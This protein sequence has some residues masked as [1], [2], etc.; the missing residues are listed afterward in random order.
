MIESG[1][2]SESVRVL[3]I[4]N[5]GI[6]FLLIIMKDDVTPILEFIATL[7]GLIFEWYKSILEFR[8]KFYLT[9]SD[10]FIEETSLFLID[11]SVYS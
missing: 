4:L 2:S 1:I 6:P 10:I 11:W 5:P 8:W 3:L 7:K 9:S